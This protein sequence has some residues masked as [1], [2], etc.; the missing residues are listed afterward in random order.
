MGVELLAEAAENGT[1]KCTGLFGRFATNIE[2]AYPPPRRTRARRCILVVLVVHG[3]LLELGVEVL[4]QQLERLAH[5]VLVVGRQLAQRLSH[6]FETTNTTMNRQE[7]PG[8]ASTG[9]R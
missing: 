5:N 3:D 7:R 9:G 2:R 6:L 4:G 8:D 1:S